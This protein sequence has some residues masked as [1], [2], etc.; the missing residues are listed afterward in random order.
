MSLRALVIPVVLALGLNCSA[1]LNSTRNRTMSEGTISGTVRG[2]DNSPVANARVEAR[3]LTG[4]TVTA[5]YTDQ[6]GG[7]MLDNL[8]AGDYEV[9][10]TKGVNE[11]RERVISDGINNSVQLRMNVRQA[12]EDG[13]TSVSVA[14]F[15]V[16]DKARKEFQKG[17]EAL[18]KNKLDEARK[19][20]EK[21][22]SVYPKY[23]DALTLRGILE[24]NDNEIQAAMS[25]FDTAMKSDPNCAMAY[26]AMGAA[27]NT[28]G[29][30][31]DAERSL[32]RA[33]SLQ[34]GAW[35]AYFELG[36]ASLG[37]GNY[38]QALKYVTRASEISQEYPP[39]HLVKAHALLGLKRYQEAV[40]EL[41]VYLT[42]DSS[43][44]ASDAA[45]KTL[46]AAR[47]FVNAQAQQMT[48]AK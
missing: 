34:P 23:A 2:V 26:M 42:R 36:K 16:P 41:E 15:K 3:D 14:Q 1:Q 25:D 9:V 48:A 18:N 6:L 43:G 22:L 4:T 30:Y 46:T 5:A 39:I 24:M 20:A 32:L 29:K 45:R 10:V 37:E 21:A 11:A 47:A 19:H 17:Q 33:A 44:P 40:T 28:T 8:P 12:A 31:Q 27:L 13:S 35:Q 7:F 38:M